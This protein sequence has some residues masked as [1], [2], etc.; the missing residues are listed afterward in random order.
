KLV[1]HENKLPVIIVP[2][3]ASTDAPC[4]KMAVL[5]HDDHSYADTIVF[6]DNPDLVLVDSGVIA[7][8]PERFLVAGMGDAFATYYEARAC[9]RS[10]AS[11]YSGA[12]ATNTA[13]V[14]AETCH[15]ILIQDSKRALLACRSNLVTPSLENIIEANILL[16][17]IGFESVGLAVAHAIAAGFTLLPETNDMM[18]GEKVAIGTL[19]QLILENAPYDE[20]KEAMDYYKTVGLPTSLKEIGITEVTE[21]KL[22]SVSSAVLGEGSCI[23][24]MPFKLDED[25][26]YNALAYVD[27]LDELIYSL[28]T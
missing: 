13:F 28:L 8:A 24:N 23:H 27:T 6:S 10:G 26:V 25:M 9:M 22:R 7:R 16:S 11:N 3:I 19:V 5:Y 18:H 20:L 17:G 4:S 21:E 12:L 15:K 1:A 14:L 2:T